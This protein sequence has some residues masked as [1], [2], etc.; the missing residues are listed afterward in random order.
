MASR[1]DRLLPVK[2]DEAISLAKQLKDMWALAQALSWA[3][4][5][6]CAKGNPTEVDRL[7]SEL[8]ELSTHHNFAHWLRIGAVYRGLARSASGERVEGLTLL[9]RE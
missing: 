2:L 9:S 1:R 4:G 7:A 5:L 3:A 8:I 6:G